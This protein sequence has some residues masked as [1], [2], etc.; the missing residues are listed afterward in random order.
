MVCAAAAKL[1]PHD[2]VPLLF[3]LF[4]GKGRVLTFEATSTVVPFSIPRIAQHG[5]RWSGSILKVGECQAVVSHTGMNTM[6]GEA[7]KAIQEAS[8]KDIGVFEGKILEAA[9]VL[10][11]ITIVVVSFLFYFMYLS[12]PGILCGPKNLLA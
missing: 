2:S 4:M 6:I 11:L 8:G 10:I 3:V 12:L 9:Q 1:F 7:A 5:R